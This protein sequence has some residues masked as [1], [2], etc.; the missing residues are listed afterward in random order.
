[1]PRRFLAMIALVVLAVGWGAIPLIVREDVPWEGLVASRV[2]FGALTLLVVMT[3]RGRLRLPDTHRFQIVV[4]G[5]LLAVHWATFF[6]ALKLTSVAVTL[7]I[8][9]L[10]P[11]SAAVLAP[12]VL[13]ERVA[14]GTYWALGMAFTGVVLVVA[15]EG[16]DAAGANWSGVG[17]A[18]I[19]AMTVAGLLLVS[20]AAVDAVGPLL[21]TTGEMI[22]AAIVLSP[23]LGAAVRGV[24]ADPVPLLIL[25]IVLTGLSFLLFWSATS[26]LPMAVVSVLMHVEPASA[27]VLAL[28]FLHETPGAW[29]WVGIGFV[30]VG[31]V[32]AAGS[33][34]EEEVL[35]A[36]AN[37]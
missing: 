1:M 27:V 10:G 34:A 36:P 21:V 17:V 20:K 35:G 16:A 33:G 8:V 25:G 6:W 15:F 31:G 5:G 7:A 26:V 18:A 29:Q 30:I 24:R 22:T 19:S 37:L 13:N 32:I 23:F 9:Y 14:R 4:A 2:W 12:R 11:V 3:G 28:M